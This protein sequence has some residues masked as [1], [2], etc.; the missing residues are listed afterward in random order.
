MMQH[1]SRSLSHYVRVWSISLTFAFRAYIILLMGNLGKTFRLA[2]KGSKGVYIASFVFQF[3]MTLFTV[4]TSFLSKVLVDALTHELEQAEFLEEFVIRMLTSN[5]GPTYLYEHMNILP[6]AV[7]VSALLTASISY[8]RFTLRVKASTQINK[9]MQLHLFSHLE[10]LPYSYYKTEKSGDLIQTCTRDLDVTRQ[11]M[12]MDMSQMTYTLFIVVLCFSVL[13]EISWKLTL[14]S[15]ALFPIMFVYSFFLIKEVRR[16]YR[17]TDDSEAEMVDRISQNL[18]GVRL[19][20][21]YN[22]ESKE[23]AKFEE[24]LAH[25]SKAYRHEKKL[26]AFFFGS[27]D[28]FIFAARTIAI[29]YAIVLVF[30]REITAGSVFISYT[31]VNMMV[32][33]LRNTATTLS[34]LGMTL[35]ATDRIQ[36][37]LSL[38]QEDLLT[39][40]DLPIRGDIEFRD[41]SFAYPDEPEKPVIQG[42][43]FHVP[44][45]STVALMGKTGSGKSSLSGLLTRLYAP[46]SGDIFIDGTPIEEFS[47]SCLR[48]N[49]VPVLQDPFL[50]SKS[51]SENIKIANKNATEKDIA[52]A[53]R[54]A[55]VDKAIEG[56]SKGYDTPVGEKGVTLSGGQKQRLAIARTV[57]SGA[58]VL[59]FDDSLSAVDAQTDLAI[60]REL[61]ALSSRHTTFI[62]THRVGT[63]KD[64]DLI[65]VLDEGKITEMGKHEDL[66]KGNGLYRRI[67]DIQ[68]AIE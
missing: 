1:F 49:V 5:R 4:F 55:S 15:L 9:R 37:L 44:Q 2:V 65:L 6:V 17:K 3:L 41:V 33:P 53:A 24:R 25:Y 21:A 54:I 27:S 28:I 16:R 60:R 31:F 26:S 63:A 30:Q 13:F 51:I 56:F 52:N 59:I 20:K 42:V 14:V 47:L 38:P 19:V 10:R 18:N 43:S 67:A 12:V 23:I 29:V 8:L 58:P 48:R 46:T 7:V 57:L 68:S 32:W 66:V 61:K 50:F 64:A 11:F 45:G 62:I 34:R 36:R 22:A 40:K 39:G 35:A